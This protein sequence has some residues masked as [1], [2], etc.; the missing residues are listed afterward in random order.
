MGASRWPGRCVFIAA[1]CAHLRQAFG[2][3]PAACHSVVF[4]FEADEASCL[5]QRAYVTGGVPRL[6]HQQQQQ[7]AISRSAQAAVDV[8]KDLPAALES[9]QTSSKMAAAF[10]MQQGPRSTKPEASAVQLTRTAIA[11]SSEQSHIT[12]MTTGRL[13]LRDVSWGRGSSSN[14][15]AFVSATLASPSRRLFF[16]IFESEASLII[17]GLITFFVGI[18]IVVSCFSKP[19]STPTPAASP[20]ERWLWMCFTVSTFVFCL[21]VVLGWWAQ[22]LTL[23]ADSPHSAADTLGFAVA[24]FIER[25]KHDLD[26]T[27]AERIDALSAG[28]NV[29]LLLVTCGVA[30]WQSLSRLSATNMPEEDADADLRKMGTGLL[31]FSISTTLLNIILLCLTPQQGAAEEAGAAL[32]KEISR[33]STATTLSDAGLPPKGA[34]NS[35]QSKI[36]FLHGIFHHRGCACH[37]VSSQGEDDAPSSSG[38]SSSTETSLNMY[39]AMLHIATDV[40]RSVVILFAGILVLCGVFS[41][42]FKADAVAAVIVGIC[43]ILGSADL[44]RKLVKQLGGEACTPVPRSTSGLQYRIRRHGAAED[45]RVQARL[46]T[47]GARAAAAS[48]NMPVPQQMPSHQLFDTCVVCS[49]CTKGPS[50]TQESSSSRKGFSMSSRPSTQKP[51]VAQKGP[52]TQTDSSTKTQTAS[53]GGSLGAIVEARAESEVA[54]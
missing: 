1:L 8:A 47:W 44:I 16:A 6:L 11:E 35:S 33:S 41:N 48:K 31:I 27:V 12:P 40:I 49:P 43:V 54:Q 24:V 19:D 42:P 2:S 13:S 25:S 52:S 50:S 28:F 51:S 21:Q 15:V 45:P 5:Q 7:Q 20:A 9:L 3:A 17:A 29:V 34:S 18:Y 23:L 38:A 4:E 37:N 53:D 10:P 46:Q 26:K 14:D 36:N 30:T 32:P 22:S 39:G